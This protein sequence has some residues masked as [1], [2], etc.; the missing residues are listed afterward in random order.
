[1]EEGNMALSLAEQIEKRQAEQYALHRQYLNTSMA[2]VQTIIGFDKIYS[3][4][5]GAYLWDIEGNR[6]LDLLSG[7]SVFNL[8]RSHPA[9]RRVIQDVLAMDRPNLVKMDCPLLAGLLA[10]GL[11]KR[12]PP[13]LDA[14]FFVNS[15]AEAVDTAL[16]FA[17]AATR[18]PRV[19]YLDHAF[20][21]LTLG[22]LP[23]NGGSSFRD[24]FEPL[25]PGFDAVV[26]N[27]VEELEQQLRRG[28]VAAFIL[29][30]IQGK[31]VH[32]PA[33]GYLPDA[34]RLCRKY[35]TLF[36]CDEV[37]VGMARTGRFLCCE[38][39]QL[40]PDLVTLSKSLG[41]GYV[42]VGA[43]ITRRA[44]HD[45]TFSRL[46]RCQVHSTTFGENELAMAAGLATLRVLDEER[47]IDNAATMGQK[48]ISG[49]AALRERHEMIAD[50]RGK[51]LMIGIEFRPPRSLALRTA[52]AA[53]EK[54]QK[55]LFA[56]LVVMALMRDHRILTQ[57]G[58]P[59]VNIIKLL[60][61]LIIGSDE[62]ET[63]IAAFD[64]VMDEASRVRGR[65]WG[66]S[67]HLIKHAL[68]Q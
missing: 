66:L 62:V 68:S 17:R 49:L 2:R 30:P 15:G 9:V 5:E 7:Y 18:R 56:Q 58:G 31:G 40:E 27:D 45:K 59:D 61:P 32:I 10:E 26:M 4:G 8:G 12:M 57:V 16:K 11:V 42:P 39:W 20:H 13:G 22:T 64:A 19:L 25:M 3:R 29:E 54:A 34:Q 67:G 38:H 52:W 41:G 60:P 36:V 50:V 44:I 65:V 63:I 48:L 14:V 53:A 51:G 46:D 1:M 33:D 37:Q 21:G 28:D 24:G 47:L 55:G 35:G 6:Y 23:I 43:T